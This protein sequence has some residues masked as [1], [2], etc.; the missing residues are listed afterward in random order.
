MGDFPTLLLIK[1]PL[2]SLKKE[3][4]ILGCFR[5]VLY[6]NFPVSWM[7]IPGKNTLKI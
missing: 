2:S 4:F 1:F 7:K 6:S 5:L 3:T